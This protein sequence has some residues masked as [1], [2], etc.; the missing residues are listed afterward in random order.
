MANSFTQASF[1]NRQASTTAATD[2]QPLIA[3]EAPPADRIQEF[4]LQLITQLQTTLDLERLLSIFFRHL[5]RHLP[6]AGLHYLNGDKMTDLHIGQLAKHSCH[7]QLTAQQQ[8]YGDISFMRNKRF[9]EAEMAFIE[10]IMDVL[11]FPLRNGL[12]YQA[13]L[14]T[15]MI[16][17]LTGLGNRGAMAVTLSREI[18]RTRR[19]QEQHVSLVMADIDHFKSI[20]D[21]YGH[22]AG[23]GVLRQVGQIIQGSIRGSDAAFRYGGEEFLFCVT[24]ST[25]ELANQVAERIRATI[26]QQ[27]RLPSWQKAVT[28][29]F[30]VAHYKNESD[31]PA[32]VARADK[33]LYRAKQQGRNQ[34]VSD[35]D[36]VSA[37]G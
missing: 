28:A 34:V 13:A 22:L 23:D 3:F 9:S 7:Y 4:R 37:V 27:V 29:S 35:S 6:V 12:K 8:H 1:G 36:E 10:S 33:A 5:K 26:A 31:W 21:R 17:P 20:N 18:E 16:D 32:L 14:A 25:P 11:L 2:D 15:A 24:N 19:H 30:G